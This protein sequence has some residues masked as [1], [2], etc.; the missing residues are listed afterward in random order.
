MTFVR[1]LALASLAIWLGGTA[2]VAVVIAPTFFRVLSTADGSASRGLVDPLF[3]EV[4]RQFHLLAYGCGAVLLTCLFIVKFIG[5]PPRAFKLRAFL[6][7]IMLAMALYSGIPL[8]AEM[9]AFRSQVAGP[10]GALADSDP[11]RARFDRLHT[12]SILLMAGNVI[13]GLVLLSWYVRE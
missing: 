4:F 3:E 6:V 1:Y 5:P 2:F 9:R 8:A 10:V 11:R 7:G 13:L 12:T